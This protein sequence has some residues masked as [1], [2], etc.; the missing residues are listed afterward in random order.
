VDAIDYIVDN[1]ESCCN[2]D[3]LSSMYRDLSPYQVELFILFDVALYL[4]MTTR[5]YQKKD[6]NHSRYTTVAWNFIILLFELITVS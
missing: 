1:I 4:L 6:I 2:I 5:Y 3:L